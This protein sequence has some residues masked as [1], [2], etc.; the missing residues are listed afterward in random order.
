MNTIFRVK[1]RREEE[2]SDGLLI[3]CK[4]TK[5]SDEE[6]GAVPTVTAL[7]K[8]VGTVDKQVSL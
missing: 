2:P 7:L 5:Q 8:F 6:A 3:T 4:K 1:R